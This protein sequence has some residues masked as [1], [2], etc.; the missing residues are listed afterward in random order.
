MHRTLTHSLVWTIYF[1]LIVY[2][3]SNNLN[4]WYA[5]RHTLIAGVL[6]ISLFYSF[7]YLAI[8]KCL[9]Y[10]KYLR[11]V[12]WGIGLLLFFYV[13]KIYLEVPYFKEFYELNP[14]NTPV[15][16]RRVVITTL[17]IVIILSTILTTL[18]NRIK[19]ERTAQAII[20]KQNEAELLYLKAQINPHFLFN[21]LNNIYSLAVVKSDQT[22]AMV[23]GLAD[24]LRYSIY[25]SLKEKVFLKDETAHIRKYLDLFS[26]TKEEQPNLQFVIC[27]EIGIH[28]IEPMILIPLVENCVK[29]GDF[30]TNPDAFLKLKLTIKEH[31]I[32]FET[33]NTKIDSNQ[34]KDKVGG[35]GI[36]NI[37]KRL[38]LKYPESYELHCEENGNLFNVLLIIN[39]L[40]S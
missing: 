29:H 15:K 40:E 10:K 18:E 2:Y 19:K 36:K 3:K 4:F 17:F 21:A 30:D 34:Q 16:E 13:L 27:G 23:L 22:P 11:F 20:A 1:I 38:A 28:K 25:E 35:V 26:M 6:N 14:N 32:I 37:K 33:T 24:L 7:G 12:V 8:N 5:L 39:E 31:K 9:E